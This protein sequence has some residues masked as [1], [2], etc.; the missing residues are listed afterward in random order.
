M[1]VAFVSVLALLGACGPIPL[2]LAEKDC[3]Q[4]ARLA[5]HPRGF[6]AVGVGADGKPRVGGQIGISTDFI[7]GRDPSSVY[8]ACVKRKSGA[9]PSRPYYDIPAAQ[10]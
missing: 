8:N 5:E 6:V 1:R 4:D 10:Q 2:A 7:A 9:F 3:L